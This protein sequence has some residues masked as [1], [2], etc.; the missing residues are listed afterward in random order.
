MKILALGATGAIGS[1]LVRSLANSGHNVSVTSRSV[2]TP[3]LNLCYL[4]GNSRDD[5][6]LKSILSQNWDC[7]VDFM[8]YDTNSFAIRVQ[9]LLQSTEQYVFLSTGR[10]LANSENALQESSPRLLNVCRDTDYLATD[11][12]ALTKA[13]Q[14]DLLCASGKTN[15]TVVRP[16]I[17]FGE[18][19]LQLGTLEKEGWL[20]RA[21]QGRSIVFCDA[22][23]DRETTLTDGADVA[24]M[25]AALI[26]RQEAHG[27]VFNLTSGISIHWS[28]V[29]R[30][31]LSALAD[32]RGK[33]T[34]VLLQDVET[35]CRTTNPAQVRYDRMYHRRF[36]TKKIAAIY[37]VSK[38]KNPLETLAKRVQAALSDTIVFGPIDWRAEA[39]RDRA[40]GE[41]ARLTEF[42][43][44]RAA[45]RYHAYRHL[46]IEMIRRLR[47]R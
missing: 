24:G 28:S 4:I 19:R 11:E 22:L 40:T 37:D 8:V 20:Y 38:I 42:S 21:S 47:R 31:Y 9:Q 6:F 36:D 44:N 34:P 16:Y 2:R 33:D 41:H 39:L 27:E 13:R 5:L 25:I 45:A 14:E 46:P 3:Q 23:M 15:W 29:L 18:A 17:T 43:G 1:L 30:T 7:I 26:G 32:K 10:V 12:Y 35:F